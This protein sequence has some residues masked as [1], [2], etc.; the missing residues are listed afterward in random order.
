M[1]NNNLIIK[2]GGTSI[3]KP[4][5]YINAISMIKTDIDY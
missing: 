3:L 1:I 5:D 4:S 2:V